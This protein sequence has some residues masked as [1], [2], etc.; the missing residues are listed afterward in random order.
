MQTTEDLQKMFR[1]SED[2]LAKVKKF[3]DE[4]SVRVY[5]FVEV[6]KVESDHH[7]LLNTIC[8]LKEK[9]TGNWCRG[10][11]IKDPRD[12]HNRFLSR[13]KAFGRALG[14]AIRKETTDL[15][16]HEKKIIGMIHSNV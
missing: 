16:D 12:N 3:V 13:R 10:I 14:C 1:L 2:E 15:N 8:I 9:S 6:D 4:S 7:N 5:R 11:T